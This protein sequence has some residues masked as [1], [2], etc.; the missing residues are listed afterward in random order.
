MLNC[1]LFLSTLSGLYRSSS[2]PDAVISTRCEAPSSSSASFVTL[3]VSLIWGN[4]TTYPDTDTPGYAILAGVNAPGGRYVGVFICA[5]GQSTRQ[6][7][8]DGSLI[9]LQACTVFQ[10]SMSPGSQTILQATS[11]GPQHS[12]RISLWAIRQVLRE[13]SGSEV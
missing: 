8:L 11:S 3:S 12:V 13:S 4:D 6:I 10:V 7:D 1:S 5:I 9:S 2:S